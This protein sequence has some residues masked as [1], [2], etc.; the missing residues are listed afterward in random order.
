LWFS[1]AREPNYLGLRVDYR[2]FTL[3]MEIMSRE[4]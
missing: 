4:L 3:S 2:S 1:L